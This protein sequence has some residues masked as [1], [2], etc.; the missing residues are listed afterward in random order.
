MWQRGTFFFLRDSLLTVKTR[1]KATYLIFAKDYGFMKIE[2][3][4]TPFGQYESDE[5]GGIKDD[6]DATLLAARIEAEG[7]KG[8]RPRR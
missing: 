1:S 7:N 3:P 2:E 8:P 6:L 5:E 4:K